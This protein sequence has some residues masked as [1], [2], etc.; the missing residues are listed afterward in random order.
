MTEQLNYQQESSIL[1]GLRVLQDIVEGSEGIDGYHRQ[2]PHFD[3]VEP[4]SSEEI[5]ELCERVNTSTVQLVDAPKTPEGDAPTIAGG[6]IF[7]SNDMTY[8]EGIQRGI[9][10]AND[11]ALNALGIFASVHEDYAFMLIVEDSDEDEVDNEF[12]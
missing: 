6:K 8:L 3:D 2:L 4:L 5:D 7:H 11:G 9:E 10:F 12:V 1:A